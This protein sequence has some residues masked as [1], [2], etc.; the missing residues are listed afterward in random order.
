MLRE[1]PNDELTEGVI[2]SSDADL[3]AVCEFARTFDGY[4]YVGAQPKADPTWPD[5]LVWR[6]G[7]MA[8]TPRGA[9]HRDGN[10]PTTL[11]ELRA[12]L[13]FEARRRHHLNS[14]KGGYDDAAY[15]PFIRALVEAIRRKVQVGELL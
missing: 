7:H 12:C 2:P 9:F 13:F 6:L 3:R 15:H 8:N 5:N 14:A 11:S 4:S 1:L 10:L